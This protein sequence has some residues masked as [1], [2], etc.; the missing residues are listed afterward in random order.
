LR[1]RTRIGVLFQQPRLAVDLS[2]T[3]RTAI[4]EPLRATRSPEQVGE[5][6]ELVMLTTDLLGRRAHEFSDGQLQRACLDRT[7]ALRLSFLICDEMTTMLDASP[8]PP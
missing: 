6:A 5:L 7:L 1:T 3:L 8:Q 2:M 4:A